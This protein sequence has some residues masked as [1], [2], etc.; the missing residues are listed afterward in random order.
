LLLLIIYITDGRG[1]RITGGSPSGFAGTNFE[2]DFGPCAG[3]AEARS[4][5]HETK[6]KFKQKI[7]VKNKNSTQ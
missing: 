3:R 5:E 4:E 6:R 2:V 1:Y 7:I